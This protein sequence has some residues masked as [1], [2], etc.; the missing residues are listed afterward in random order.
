MLN[1]AVNGFGRIGRR[2][3][4]S[5]LDKQDAVNI[6]IINDPSPNINLCN[7]FRYDSSNPVPLGRKD[8][9]YDDNSLT[10]R[11]K[12][13]PVTHNKNI[14]E[15]SWKGIDVLVDSSGQYKKLKD[16][17]EHV[18][19]GGAKKV[20]VTAPAEAE[21]SIVYGVNE[22]SYKGEEIISTSSCTTN[23]IIP[24]IDMIHEEYQIEYGFLT[25]I[26]AYTNDQRLHD[27]YHSDLRR[28]RAAGLN[29]I[30]TKTGASAA[31]D[32][33]FPDL[34]GRFDGHAVRV[35]VALGSLSDI[36]LTF[37]KAHNLEDLNKLIRSKI[38]EKSLE[39]IV[40]YN[41]EPIV[42]SDVIGS[43]YSAIYDATLTKT[44]GRI[45]KLS[46]WYDNETGYSQRIVDLLEYMI[47]NKW[48]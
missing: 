44:H 38:A 46:A 1:I 25:T 20:I 14:A 45:S 7:L 18:N 43:K 40:Y 39:K 3:I 28:S 42:S 9:T 27:S 8:C 32:Y 4:N 21:I 6:A 34:K 19:T 13:I 23:S 30:P 11:N 36:V 26:H 47:E 16:I 2:V 41:T 22:R 33:F 5:L 35:P 48:V 37:K 15:G 29:I 17:R 10:I 31:V 12:N 24:I